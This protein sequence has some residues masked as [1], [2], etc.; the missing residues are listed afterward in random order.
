MSFY[1]I[2][3]DFFRS[4]T[5]K[6]L[7]HPYDDI[8]QS[9]TGKSHINLSWTH[10]SI[11]MQEITP[12]GRSWYEKEADR[13]MWSIRTLRRSVSSL[14]G[15]DRLYAAKYLTYMPT[16][17]ELRRKIERQKEFYRLQNGE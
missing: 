2:R 16:K 1:Q 10:Y 6:P 4:L 14:N 9:L 12:E 7:D 17:D 3:P 5:G 13:E 8:F 15:S 11:I